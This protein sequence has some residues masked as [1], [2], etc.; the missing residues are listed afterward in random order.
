MCFLRRWVYFLLWKLWLSLLHFL[1]P[2][3]E[4][5]DLYMN[6]LKMLKGLAKNVCK[7]S[8]ILFEKVGISS[9]NC[10]LVCC[11]F[12][13]SLYLLF[14]NVVAYCLHCVKAPKLTWHILRWKKKLAQVLWIYQALGVRS[15]DCNQLQYQR[16]LTMSL[17]CI[18][19]IIP[20][21]PVCCRADHMDWNLRMAKP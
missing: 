2:S 18:T 19:E 15:H 4:F 3:F 7:S 16:S 1:L 14:I 12:F 8:D 21:V 13:P 6:M 11:T 10:G 9:S 5:E 20:I 17:Q